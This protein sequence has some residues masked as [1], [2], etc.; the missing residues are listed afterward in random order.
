M[1]D[2]YAN[3]RAPPHVTAH[4]NDGAH[5]FLLPQGATLA[6]LA[7]RIDE[8][9]AL[10]EGAPISIHVDFDIPGLRPMKEAASWTP[11]CS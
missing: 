1:L 11:I 3:N 8:L 9:A 6:E 4:F 5:T 7:D 10:H 2:T